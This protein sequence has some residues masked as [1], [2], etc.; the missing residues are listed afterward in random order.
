[1]TVHN[2]LDA[3]GSLVSGVA[4]AA[5]AAVAGRDSSGAMVSGLA[6]T[7]GVATWEQGGATAAAHNY[8]TQMRGGGG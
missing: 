8:Y 4:T 3:S 7:I 6:T 5:G 2:A 1:M